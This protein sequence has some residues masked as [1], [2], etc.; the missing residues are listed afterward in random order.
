[1]NET[2]TL[3]QAIQY[4]SNVDTCIRHLSAKRWPDGI[5]LC[6]TCGSAD[7]RF[8]ESRKLWECKTKHPKRQFSIKVG[9]V[10]EDSPIGLDKWMCAFWMLANCKNG[11]SSY[12]IH[13]AIG[14][15]QKSAWFML[16]RIRLAL[17]NGSIIK[18]GGSGSPVEIDETFIGGKAKN[19]HEA[20]RKQRITRR[21]AHDKAIVF[22]ILERGGLVH[23]TTIPN[24]TAR[25][26]APILKAHVED[27]SEVM[28]DEMT[29]Y[30]SLRDT[31]MHQVVNHAVEYVSGQ[32]HTNGIENFW[33]LLKRGLNGTYV[34]VEPF[35]LDRYL[36][37]Q[38][39]RFNNRKTPKQNVTDSDRFNLAL[40][41][42]VGKRLTF[43][44]L[45]GKV[46]E[47]SF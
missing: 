4:F 31:Y 32:V 10:M 46:C 42:I 22:G 30:N 47:T 45:T 12:E 29:G 1:M 24:R 40:S 20:K 21:G 38:V 11:V 27:G 28:T 6:P 36:D 13:R 23:A 2:K 18:M 17:K 3:Q 5:V 15:T 39:F 35:H 19:M 37:E 26:V 9:T 34:A 14:I 41:Q 25:T 16:H 43:A 8:M 44:E 33:S 7:V